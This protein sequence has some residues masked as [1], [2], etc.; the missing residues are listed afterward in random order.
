MTIADGLAL[1][2]TKRGWGPDNSTAPDA[3]SGPIPTTYTDWVSSND[4]VEAG[5][6]AI[7]NDL[8]ISA[9]ATPPASVTPAGWTSMGASVTGTN[10][11]GKGMRLNTSFKILTTADINAQVTGM[12][13]NQNKRANTNTFKFNRPLQS[14]TVRDYKITAPTAGDPGDVTVLASGVAAYLLIVSFT[15]AQNSHA[16]SNHTWSVA[17][18]GSPH[19][20]GTFNGAKGITDPNICHSFNSFLS[21]IDTA[22]NIVMGVGDNGGWNSVGGCALVLT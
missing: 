19:N 1:L 9:D 4:N 8:A 20:Q 21:R 16:Q 13:G 15:H 3:T 6:L 22:V 2:H 17:P 14:C 7:L 12:L 10:E 11:F 5:D 18:T